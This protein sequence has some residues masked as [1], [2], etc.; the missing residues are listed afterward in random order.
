MCVSHEWSFQ[1][2][3]S[4]SSLSL[5]GLAVAPLMDLVPCFLLN[6][7]PLSRFLLEGPSLAE[8]TIVGPSLLSSSSLPSRGKARDDCS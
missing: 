4:S 3:S 2:S 5:S 8:P 6:L 1:S 7:D